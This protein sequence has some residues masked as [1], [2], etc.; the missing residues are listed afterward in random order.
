MK[1]LSRLNINLEKVMKH[2]EL[3]TLRGAYGEADYIT[4]YRSY[5]EGGPCYIQGVCLT[6]RL[7]CD[8]YCPG[9]YAALCV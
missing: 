1:K 9:S 2:E 3:M 5:P 7:W 8:L 4:C 6:W